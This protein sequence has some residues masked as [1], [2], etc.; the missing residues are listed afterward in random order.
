MFKNAMLV[1][2]G[3]LELSAHGTVIFKHSKAD[4]LC[5]VAFDEA[6]TMHEQ[7]TL[8]DVYAIATRLSKLIADCLT[9]PRRKKPQWA[10]LVDAFDEYPHHATDNKYLIR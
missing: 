5:E 4:K 2:L 1:D 3:L 8:D 7:P 6:C 10:P 9:L